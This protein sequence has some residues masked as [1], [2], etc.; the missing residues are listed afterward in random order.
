[1][2]GDWTDVQ[3]LVDRVESN[4][5]PMVIAKVLLA[6]R[7]GE[8]NSIHDALSKARSVLGSPITAAGVKGYRRSYDAVLNLHMTHELELIYQTTSALNPT[9]QDT[10]RGQA[11][12][13]TLSD[14]SQEFATRLNITLPTFRSRE[15]LLSM[16]RTAFILS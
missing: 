16:R 7:T 11:H 3:R 12:S 6:M 14:L 5:S 1:M 15:P 8:H 2:V 13:Q 4:S 9:S 10:S